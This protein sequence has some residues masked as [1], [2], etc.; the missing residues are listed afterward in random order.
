[1][2]KRS[3]LKWDAA[4]RVDA[5]N[6]K[7]QP[8]QA[9]IKVFD[10]KSPKRGVESRCAPHTNINQFPQAPP[11]QDYSWV[12]TAKPVAAGLPDDHPLSPK[13]VRDA[14]RER[15][16]REL[17]S[18]YAASEAD[19]DKKSNATSF[20]GSS[21]NTASFRS[22]AGGRVKTVEDKR[23]GAFGEVEKFKGHKAGGHFSSKT[24]SLLEITRKDEIDLQKQRDVAEAKARILLSGGTLGAPANK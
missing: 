14:E 22:P 12:R 7:Y 19:S 6:Y 11:E 8:P 4:P 21:P 5:Y 16:R 1:M 24:K 2:D 13:R 15:E 9:A 3:P 10:E 18:D 17:G 20:S 23:A